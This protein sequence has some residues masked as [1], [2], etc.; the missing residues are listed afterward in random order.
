[1]PTPKKGT[2]LKPKRHDYNVPQNIWP[3]FLDVATFASNM[4]K[5][6]TEIKELWIALNSL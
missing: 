2:T 4:P 1:M 5:A 6:L 3:S